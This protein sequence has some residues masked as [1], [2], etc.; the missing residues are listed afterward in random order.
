MESKNN[1][2]VRKHAFYWRYDTAEELDLLNRLWPPVSKRINFFTPTRK[3]VGYATTTDG[4]R[5]RAY[6]RPKTPWLRV[7]ESG[8]LT[9]SQIKTIEDQ[10]TSLNPADLTRQINTIQ[11]ALTAL[12]R[13]KTDA[14]TTRRHLNMASLE[15]SIRRLQ[16][17]KQTASPHAHHT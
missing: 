1:H 10:V 9:H 2:I 13:D 11:T 14:M 4:R 12:A 16:T 15:P 3:P 8:L 6:D 7:K 5:K 17:T